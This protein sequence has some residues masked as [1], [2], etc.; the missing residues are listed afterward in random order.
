MS[1][2]NLVLWG[3]WRST[4]TWRVRIALELKGLSYEYRPVNL[5][6]GEQRGDEFLKLNP[7]GLVPVLGIGIGKDDD[8]KGDDCCGSQ[9][10]LIRQSL[11][12][13]NWIDASFPQEPSL[14]RRGSDFMEEAH[15]WELSLLIACDVHPLQNLR[16]L[17][18]I[19]EFFSGCN[20]CN[21]CNGFN[22]CNGENSTTAITGTTAKI[23]RAREIIEAGLES[24]QS[25][26]KN[27]SS[28]YCVG[29]SIS[30]AD[31]TLL[32]QLYN[33]ERFGIDIEQRFPVL[34]RIMCNLQK[35][36]SFQRAHPDAMPDCIP[37]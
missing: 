31:L 23:Q 11:A 22:G 12:I 1:A 4:A 28:D 17:K 36:P 25:L 15:I 20:S 37:Q 6:K 16:Q 3:Y 26:L 34:H 2:D 10:K 19:E 32:P 27:R 24:F 13:I 18:K 7:D 21:G 14:V 8:C 30:M 29:N 5:V 35:L 33:G 9:K